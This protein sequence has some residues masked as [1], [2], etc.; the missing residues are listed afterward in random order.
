MMPIPVPTASRPQ[1]SA[2]NE[3]E[4]AQPEQE[5]TPQV[6]HNPE[7]TGSEREVEREPS[8][9]AGAAAPSPLPDNASSVMS[10]APAQLQDLGNNISAEA[11]SVPIPEDDDDGLMAE[12]LFLASSP[13]GASDAD[14]RELTTFTTLQTSAWASGPPLAE[15]NLPFVEQPLMCNEH[16]AYCLE[17]PL[18]AKDVKRWA[19]E[20]APEHLTLLASVG[21]RARAEVHV[22]DLT[23]AEQ[24]LFDEAKAKEL[25]CWIQ[26]SAIKSILRRHLNPEQIL[27]SRWILTWKNPEPGET[28]RRAKARLVVLGYQD[29]KLTEVVRDAPTLSKEGRALVL[30]TIASSRVEL[31]SFD[32][33]TAFLRGK[34]D[35]QNPLAMEPPKELRKE[36]GMSDDEVC[37][38]LGNAYGRVDAPLLFYKELSKQLRELGF[39]QHPLE[40]C[41]FLLYTEGVLNGILGVH[42]DDGVCGGDS[43]FTQKIQALQAKLPFGS[44][45]FRNFIFTGIHLEQFPDYSIRAS[46]GEY[47]RNICQI[48]VG[49]PRRANPEAPVTEAERSK[50]RGLVGSLQYAVTHTRPDM[51]AKLGEL[52]GHTGQRTDPLASQYKVLRETQE[53]EQVSIHFLPIPPEDITFVS[54]GDAS[55]ASSKNLNPHQGALVCATD[56]RLNQ[57]CEAPLSPLTWTSKKIP[58]VARST[59]SAEAYATS[60]AVDMLGWMR[61]LWGVVHVPAFRWQQPEESFRKLNTAIVVTDV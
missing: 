33:K 42:V 10:G 7:G 8:T 29:P 53:Q 56:S 15:D 16:Q 2:I 1:V 22:K 23:R 52:Q 37:Q 25:Q 44:R 34:A 3:E 36:L 27:K 13:T 12:S 60:K 26:T 5:L 14:G 18:K 4:I 11:S 50:L 21:K 55:F 31:S 48:D 30:Q 20:V 54:F 41:V 47:V 57:N 28:Q 6:S 51:A 43:K 61:A 35:E 9:S 49:R 46:Q 45:K 24:L 39:I 32:I 38:L 59:L 19:K 40:P 17:I 58:R